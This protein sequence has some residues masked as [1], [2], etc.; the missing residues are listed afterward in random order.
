MN[1]ST[2]TKEMINKNTVFMKGQFFEVV[3][4]SIIGRKSLLVDSEVS[5]AFPGTSVN[6][7][8]VNEAQ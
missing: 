5:T 4:D 6:T 7:N 1:C 8:V 3:R 2:I